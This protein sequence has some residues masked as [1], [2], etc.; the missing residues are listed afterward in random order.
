M[1]RFLSYRLLFIILLFVIGFI[2]YLADTGSRN[3][4]FLFIDS[5]P[6]GDKISHFVLMGTLAMLAN[7]ALGY[8][9]VRLGF[10]RLDTGTLVIS[11][12]VL[13]EEF[14]QAWNPHRTFDT[15]DLFAD[16]A[17]I[18]LLSWLGYRFLYKQRDTSSK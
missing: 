11:A 16:F 8:R 7:L 4:A 13:A 1:T 3:F 5:L 17:G 18:L 14:T 9:H 10:I 15:G 6:Y 12:L 2:I